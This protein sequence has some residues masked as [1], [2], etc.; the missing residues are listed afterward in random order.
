MRLPAVGRPIVPKEHG[1][2]AVLYGSFLV[3]V[4]VAGRVTLPVELFLLGITAAVF[5][6][7]S[8]P[9]LAR[10]KASEGQWERCRQALTWFLLYGAISVAA[11]APL[12]VVFRMTFLLPF[13]VGAAF[14]LLLRA[15]LIRGRDDRTLA[16]EL[17]G[18]AGLT[19]VGPVAHAVSVGSVRSISTMLWLLL[20]LF[21]AS[22]VFY[23]RMRV[24]GV[25]ARRR[26]KNSE[27]NPG[28][29]PC[30]LYHAVLL[31]AI[32]VLF[33]A[34]LVPWPVLL[35]YAPALW[36]AAVGLRREESRLNLRRLGWSEVAVATA[37]VLILIAAF[38]LNPLAG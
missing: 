26:G 20:F 23:V 22:G 27:P 4:G 10:A 2:W 34:R 12:L 1:V 29:W 15:F 8:L 31:V 33:L 6:N 19:M 11:M 37:F 7:G 3:G 18:V 14:F 17:I 5:A 13:G 38:R 16:G 35:A 21:F 28:R 32:P 24:H 36:R 30:V 9:T 25:V